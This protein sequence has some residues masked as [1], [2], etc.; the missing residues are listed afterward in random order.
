MIQNGPAQILRDGTVI[1]PGDIGP[2]ANLIAEKAGG[3]LT[4]RGEYELHGRK[5]NYDD[6]GYMQRQALHR[7]Y[8]GAAYQ[9]IEPWRSTLE[10]R[11][12]INFQERDNLELLNQQ[13]RVELYNV[14]RYKNF[15]E[16]YLQAH[17]RAASLDDREVGDGA[18]LERP[19][20]FGF[21][22]P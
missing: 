17:Y 16:V 2:A 22:A 19:R 18:A 5:V 7:F 10:T 8:A 4:L 13:R 14:T 3:K 20:R 6:L 9:T 12:G 21:E 15:W 11:T 1:K